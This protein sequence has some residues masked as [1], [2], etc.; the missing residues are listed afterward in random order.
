MEVCSGSSGEVERVVV[1]KSRG[2]EVHQQARDMKWGG[3][4][5]EHSAEQSA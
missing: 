2:A 4:W 5:P 1:P 3:L